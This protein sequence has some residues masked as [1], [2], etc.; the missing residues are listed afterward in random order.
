MTNKKT[1]DSSIA[2]WEEGEVLN[3]WYFNFGF[4]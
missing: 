3:I 1:T 4:V 2:D